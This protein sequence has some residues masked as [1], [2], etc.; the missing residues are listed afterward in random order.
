MNKQEALERML[1]ECRKWEGARPEK[2]VPKGEAWGALVE[3]VAAS[4]AAAY[5]DLPPEVLGL[6]G[7]AALYLLVD[8]TERVSGRSLDEWLKEHSAPARKPVNGVI[9][10][11]VEAGSLPSPRSW[12]A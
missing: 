1:E 7:G 8:E 3:L 11:V 12:Y 4:D 9:G 6:I 5:P 2:A 10:P